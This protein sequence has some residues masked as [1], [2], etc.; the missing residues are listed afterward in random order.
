MLSVELDAAEELLADEVLAAED[1]AAL[2][3]GDQLRLVRNELDAACTCL[4]RGLQDL[5]EGDRARAVEPGARVGGGGVEYDVSRGGDAGCGEPRDAAALVGRVEGRLDPDARQVERLGDP[6][7]L[8]GELGRMHENAVRT[9]ALR[10]VEERAAVLQ[11]DTME[12]VGECASG[13]L[14]VVVEGD[15]PVAELARHAQ[16]LDLLEAGAE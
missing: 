6:G 10:L 3:V 9:H 16:R 12:R 8:D 7:T 11:V 5:G 4:V 13:G 2:V 1:A 14:G 15:G